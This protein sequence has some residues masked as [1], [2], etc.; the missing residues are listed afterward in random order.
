MQLARSHRNRSAASPR[1]HHGRRPLRMESLERRSPRPHHGRR[2]LRM[3]SLERREVLS[4]APTVTL[5]AGLNELY[6]QGTDFGDQVEI[7][8][9]TGTNQLEVYAM[10]DAMAPGTAVLPHVFDAS[11]VN[12]ILFS[13]GKGNDFYANYTGI[14]SQADGG[15]GND[16]LVGEEGSDVLLGGSGDDWLAGGEDLALG[17][18]RARVAAA[19]VVESPE[20]LGSPVG[21]FLQQPRLGRDVVPL[22]PVE[23]GPGGLRLGLSGR[24]R[25]GQGAGQQQQGQQQNQRSGGKDMAGHGL[26]RGAGE[27]GRVGLPRVSL[28][29]QIEHVVDHVGDRAGVSAELTRS[30]ALLA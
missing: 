25:R 7:I 17:N 6:I 4:A 18:R 13:G 28:G 30:Y 29:E 24:G 16:V 15:A 8:L 22:W 11:K 19:A 14:I 12:Q 26:R 10:S 2:P 27:R 5:L 3:E 20:Q 23:L 21:P 9:N 1:P